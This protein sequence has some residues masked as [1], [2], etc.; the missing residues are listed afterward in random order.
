[1]YKDI[2]HLYRNFGNVVSGKLVMLNHLVKNQG[3]DRDSAYR[4]IVQENQLMS[5]T[6]FQTLWKKYNQVSPDIKF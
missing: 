3:N 1:M 4:K 6:A 2:C 5:D